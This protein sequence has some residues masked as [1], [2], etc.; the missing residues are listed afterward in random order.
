VVRQFQKRSLRN[1]VLRFGDRG[2]PSPP[3]AWVSA[4]LSTLNSTRPGPVGETNSILSCGLYPYSGQ[5]RHRLHNRQMPEP[6]SFNGQ[7]RSR[8]N[9]ALAAEPRCVA[10]CSSPEPSMAI[11]LS[12]RFIQPPRRGMVRAFFPTT[13]MLCPSPQGQHRFQRRTS[14]ETHSCFDSSFNVFVNRY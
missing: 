5:R 9:A 3:V 1:T 7:E 4:N 2:D 14:R 11:E 6:C 13:R 8:V 10:D 12:F